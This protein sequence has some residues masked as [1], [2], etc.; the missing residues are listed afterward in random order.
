MRKFLLLLVAAASY[1]APAAKKSP[2]PAWLEF[3]DPIITPAEK[4]AWLALSPAERPKYEEDFWSRK[5]ITAKEYSERIAYIDAQFGS[6]KQGSGANTDQGRVYLSLGAPN[7][8]TRIPSSRI[9]QPLEIWYYSVVPGV[10]NTEVHLMFFQKNGTGLLKLYS[11]SVDTIRALLIPQASTVNMFGPN[12]DL[13][14]EEI[15]NSV[16]VSPAEDEIVSAA[17][18]VAAGVRFEE[19]ATIIGKVSSPVYM[20]GTPMRTEVTSRLIT[21]RP[22]LEAVQTVSAFGGSQVDLRIEFPVQREIDIEVLEG[23]VTVYQNQLRFNYPEAQPVIYTHRLDLLPGLHR[24]VFT[25]DGKPSPYALE[26]PQAAKI[27]E[28]HRGSVGGDVTGRN[29]PFEFGGRQ[30]ELNPD[31][32]FAIVALPHPG[33]V[34]WMIRRG[35]EVLWRS[36]SEGQQIASVEL[37][38][39]GIE[40]G[41]YK[42]EALIG[43]SSISTDLVIGKEEGKPSNAKVVSFNANLSPARRF[44][45]VGH[46]WLLRNRL[47]EARRSLQASLATAVTDEARIE[48]ARADAL[49][50]NLDAARDLVE[51][52]LKIQP[53]NFE[54]LTVYAYIEA[55]FQDYPVAAQ[56]YRRALAVQDSPAVRAALAKLPAETNATER[57]P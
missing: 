26:V 22:N 11:P 43:E 24:V 47:D 17:V 39:G 33:K 16:Q 2:T 20:L 36:F 52:V 3:V 40:P 27:G 41:S 38:S 18:N 31:G 7:K 49:G 13:N 8:I 57:V 50:G 1:A 6:T 28:I 12:D 14:E 21:S 15:R 53:N 10:L 46:Q 56:L 42:M 30:V 25:V 55:G 48:L 54:A 35:G 4:K 51:S 37:P 29:T 5:A 34:T 9:F 23:N 32:R 44:A 45:F 19:N